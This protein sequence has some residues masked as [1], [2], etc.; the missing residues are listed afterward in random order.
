MQLTKLD[1]LLENKLD[2]G[3]TLALFIG[4]MWTTFIHT[5]FLNRMPI[6]QTRALLSM[7][8]LTEEPTN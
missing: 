1:S 7:L 5:R 8:Q 2:V 6:E 4:F 3:G